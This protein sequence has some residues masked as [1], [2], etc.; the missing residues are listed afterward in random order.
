[1]TPEINAASAILV[2]MV[3]VG[4]IAAAL[5]SKRAALRPERPAH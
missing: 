2:G 1:V 5:I 4:V 3:A